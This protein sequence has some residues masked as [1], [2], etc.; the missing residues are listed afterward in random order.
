MANVLRRRQRQKA[1]GAYVL[2]WTHGDPPPARAR[3]HPRLRSRLR[4]ALCGSIGRGKRSRR[5][6]CGDGFA[7]TRTEGDG[8]RSAPPLRYSGSTSARA[9]TARAAPGP[10]NTAAASSPSS[11][12]TAPRRSP[13]RRPLR[14]VDAATSS[15][16]TRRRPARR[17]RLLARPAGPAHRPDGAARRRRPL[18]ADQLGR[19]VPL[20]RRRAARARQPRRGGLLHV[21]P[22]Q[23]RGRVPLP[24][25]RA[26]R[27]APTTCP[28]AR[29]CATSRP[30]SA[31][32]ETIGIGKGSVTARRLRRRR[33]DR[34]RRARTPAPTTRGCCPR[35]RRPRRN[36]AKIIAVNPLPEA[37]LIRFKNPQKLARRARR[38]ASP[39]ADEFLQIRLGGDMALFQALGQAAAGGRGRGARHA[40]STATSS[41]RTRAGSP[42]T[43]RALA[44]LDLGR[45]RWRR[46]GSTAAQIERV[47][48]RCCADAERTIAC[49][50]MGLTQHR[51]AVATIREIVNVLLLRGM[52][53]KPGAGPVPGARALQRAGRPHDGHLGEAA[54][55]SSSTRSDDRFGIAPP[56]EHGVDTVDAIRAMRDGRAKVFMAHGRQ[57]RRGH[58]RHRRHR[59]G[60]AQLR[61]DRAGLD[62]AQPHARRARAR[63]R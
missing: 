57:L 11:A 36:G 46:P 25:V 60:A 58:A 52:I 4:R 39:L 44:R 7:A 61:A 53:G 63:R 31:L 48:R 51:H 54:A 29:T 27:S 17:V 21:R 24:A 2:G 5:R 16:R 23:Q 1:G 42:S 8:R 20:D 19:G 15:P 43:R 49:W 55:R 56:R 28:T 59:G 37:G 10:R 14:R 41:P 3:R 9:S 62:Q 30:A 12:R 32:T 35:W 6:H 26:R 50:A 45:R 38:A 33:P 47:G 34:R 18:R 22:H 13:R 40:C